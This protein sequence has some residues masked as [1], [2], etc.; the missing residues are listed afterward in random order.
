MNPVATTVDTCRSVCQSGRMRKHLRRTLAGGVALAVGIVPAAI[1]AAPATAAPH[2]APSTA[3]TAAPDDYDAR[4]DPAV[5]GPLAARAAVLATRPAVRTLRSRLGEQGIVDIDPLTGTPRPVARLDGFRTGPSRKPA[6]VVARDYLK[7]HA[8]LFGVDP[9]TLRLRRDYVD[10][11][12]TPHL[13]FLQR[14][15]DVPV[16]GNGI[17]ADVARNGALI[18]MTGSPVRQ[19]PASLGAARLTAGQALDTARRDARETRTT[20]SDKAGLV[21]FPTVAGLRLGYQ[22]LTMQT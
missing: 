6:V 14:V 1:T 3:A 20:T 18:Q 5:T 4:Q 21:A 13:S 15:G 9:A 7:A 17:R 8:D 16:F 19:V 12:G 22:T 11:D 10:I 2:P